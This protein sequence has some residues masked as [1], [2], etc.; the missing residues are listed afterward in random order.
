MKS[1]SA[2]DRTVLLTTAGALGRGDLLFGFAISLAL[3]GLCVR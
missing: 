3:P 1:R 2:F